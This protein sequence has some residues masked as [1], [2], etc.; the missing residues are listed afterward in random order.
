[1]MGCATTEESNPER[2]LV[3]GHTA[4]M[5]GPLLDV[6]NFTR[7]PLPFITMTVVEPFAAKLVMETKTI[8]LEQGKTAELALKLENVPDVE[9]VNFRD[10]PKGTQVQSLGR[11]GNR[12]TFVLEAGADAEPG[13][14][15]IS[16][17]A[18]VQGRRASASILLTVAALS[19]PVGEQ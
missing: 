19:A 3:E 11:K 13:S 6:W 8:R 10:L 9:L 12:E 16:A 18:Q 14:F 7:R 1:M 5:L 17:E 4:M 2:R 15:A